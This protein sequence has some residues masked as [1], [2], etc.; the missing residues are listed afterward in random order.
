MKP[1]ARDVVFAMIAASVAA[2]AGAGDFFEPKKLSNE[3]QAVVDAE[4]LGSKANPIRCE[5]P[6]GER[7]YLKRLRCPSG[8]RPKYKRAGSVG[9]G[10]YDT[11]MDLYQ[12]TCS[13]WPDTVDIYMDM[14][15]EGYTEKRPVPRFSVE[16]PQ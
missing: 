2:S 12:A 15:H 13:E 1:L 10:P 16:T 5:A 4:P 14:Y 6:E 8:D 11:I 3:Q 7:A 9:A